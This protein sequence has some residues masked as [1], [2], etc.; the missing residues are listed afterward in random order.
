MPIQMSGYGRT[1]METERVQ[2]LIIYGDFDDR[3]CSYGNRHQ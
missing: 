2:N 1:F 3:R